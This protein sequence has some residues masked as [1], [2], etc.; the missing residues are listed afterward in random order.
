[1]TFNKSLAVIGLIATVATPATATDLSSVKLVLD[2]TRET[3]GAWLDGAVGAFVSGS[4]SSATAEM[5]AVPAL[6]SAKATSATV[7]AVASAPA[8]V[9]SGSSKVA[10]TRATAAGSSWS[11]AA[12][13]LATNLL[14]ATLGNAS[15]TKAVVSPTV[16][17]P[18][19][20]TPAVT[21]PRVTAPVLVAPAIVAVP[22]VA[23]PAVSAPS[24]TSATAGVAAATS[25][26]AVASST[27]IAGSGVS[28]QASIA[29]LTKVSAPTTSNGRAVWTETGADT[30]LDL[31]VAS[32][33]AS[34]T[35]GSKVAAAVKGAIIN[36]GET[37]ETIV[38]TVTGAVSGTVGTVVDKVGEIVADVVETVTAPTVS[39]DELKAGLV[40]STSPSLISTPPGDQLTTTPTTPAT[41]T[42][43]EA[44]S[45][46]P[47]TTTPA[48]AP[49]EN[50]AEVIGGNGTVYYVD[51]AAGN[52]S[53]SGKSASQA[54]KR[55][56]GDTAAT[57]NAASAVLKGGDTI[58]FKG[59]TA[60]RGTIVFKHSGDAGN[61]I[62]YTGTGFGNGQAIWDG[63]DEVTSSVPCS[64]AAACG[65]ASNWQ[66]LRLVTYSEPTAANRKLFDAVGPLYESQSPVLSDPF[67]DD[68]LDQ[69]VTIPVA[70]A[71]ALAA[72]R[73]V[74]A[75]LAAAAAGQSNARIA[76][77]IYGNTIIERPITSVSGSTVYFDA[78]GV[79][80]YTDRDGKAAIV[81][82][83]KA[84]TKP[85]L[86]A[87]IGAGKAIVYPRS[88]GGS[89]L[90]VGTGRYAFDL[91]GRS[92]LTVHGFQ[93][94]RGTGSR[95]STREGVGVANYGAAVSNIRI[96]N[97]SF[98]GYSMQNGYG[99]VMLNN[100]TNLVVRNNR[101]TNL[102][103]ASGF[104]F[105]S[106]VSN[107]TVENNAMTKLGRTGI[108][109]GG[110]TGGRVNGNILSAMS[111]VHGNGMSYYGENKDITISGNC[112]F[113]T[114]R[115][116]TFYG[117][118]SGGGVN[119]LSFTGNIFVTSANGTSAVYSWGSYTRRVALDNN[120]ALGTKAGFILHS[121]DIDVSAT[122]NRTS[123]LLINGSKVTPTG[124]TI[125]A[126]DNSAS[127][128]DASALNLTTTSCSASSAQSALAVSIR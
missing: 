111:G 36:L 93:F 35:A 116:L 18:A 125:Q 41:P 121:T 64:S 72:G 55:A 48:P 3:I 60:Y 81:G 27:K 58:R 20:S 87:V 2:D 31:L 50:A 34:K 59:G 77:W 83:V 63:A 113:D 45:N 79:K 29:S 101:L 42:T 54:W 112:V 1:M 47:D 110:V 73:V 74:N 30:A 80:P 109:L 57:G 15:N 33:D 119:N 85:G 98:N 56:P 115:P 28:A 66:N 89:Q 14:V 21:A 53:S 16:A 39:R 88:N 82:S 78:T 69:F 123:G 122:R 128:A 23:A 24:I 107:L 7:A 102:E 40:V 38:E 37:I 70:Q 114:I 99:M 26:A 52:D 86:F 71:S 6:S 90:Y 126:N 84:V 12:A 22:A 25:A 106:S 91:R 19:V 103:G 120:V 117:G 118:G 5:A 127:L 96:E 49:D 75:T 10:V 17:V 65:G 9:S 13:D 46:T 105:G 62:I 51:F 11:E 43:P 67:W 92:N 95:G 32:Y 108:Y 104:R 76:I 61:P 100:V 4:G 97:N 8:P 94:I 124:W 44:P 68:D